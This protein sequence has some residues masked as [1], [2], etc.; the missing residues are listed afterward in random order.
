MRQLRELRKYYWML[1]AEILI[2]SQI[3]Y[4]NQNSKS[5]SI[6]NI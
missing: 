6:L 1:N 3:N 4:N 5:F 2:I